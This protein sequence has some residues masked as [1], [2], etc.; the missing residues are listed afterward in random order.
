MGVGSSS[1][2]GDVA[3]SVAGRDVVDFDDDSLD[4]MALCRFASVWT[5]PNALATSLAIRGA[6]GDD[7]AAAA[8]ANDGA[9]GRRCATTTTEKEKALL[10]PSTTAAKE[11]NAASRSRRRRRDD[12]ARKTNKKNKK[13]TAVARRTRHVALQFS[14]D[15]TIYS[16]FAQNV[17]VLTDASVEGALFDALERTRLIVTPP[18]EETRGRGGEWDDGHDERADLVEVLEVRPHGQGGAR[19]RTGDRAAA[20]ERLPPRSPDRVGGSG[21]GGGRELQLRSCVVVVRNDF[22]N[23]CKMNCE[24]VSNFERVLVL[25]VNANPA[26]PLC[27]MSSE[28]ALV[29]QHCEYANVNFGRTVRNF[30]MSRKRSNVGGRITPSRPRGHVTSSTR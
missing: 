1:G 15:G 12:D 4:P 7:A 14:Y 11:T 6:E 5:V 27:E 28:S 26:K 24:Q 18:E 9:N 16:G 22:R 30:G 25:D 3:V 20:Q 23:M 2:G 13:A 21:R 29:L 8:V 17:G 19:P 10:L